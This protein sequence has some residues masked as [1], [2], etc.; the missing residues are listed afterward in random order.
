MDLEKLN[1]FCAGTGIWL[2]LRL[3]RIRSVRRGFLGLTNKSFMGWHFWMHV[4]LEDRTLEH[5][6]EHFVYPTKSRKSQEDSMF[7]ENSIPEDVRPQ[8]ERRKAEHEVQRMEKEEARFEDQ[9]ANGKV[10]V[11]ESLLK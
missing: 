4:V 11:D 10:V 1:G 5:F 8:A 3:T 9:A 2:I 7:R 6:N